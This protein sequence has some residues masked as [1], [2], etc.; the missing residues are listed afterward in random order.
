MLLHSMGPLELVEPKFPPK[1]L[2]LTEAAL[3]S[4]PHSLAAVKTHH[5][6]LNVLRNALDNC[7]FDQF[8]RC[9]YL[10]AHGAEDWV[11]RGCVAKLKINGSV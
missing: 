1:L 9:Q 5:G 8:R 6:N 2:F 4:M 3:N 11:R 7:A 10:I